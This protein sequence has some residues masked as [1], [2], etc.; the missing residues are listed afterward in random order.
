MI[1]VDLGQ[2]LLEA[3]AEQARA[4]R[5]AGGVEELQQ[6]GPALAEAGE[7]LEVGAGVRIEAHRAVRR[8]HR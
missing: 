4:H 5:R 2:R 7:Q 6:R 8:A 3:G 1:G